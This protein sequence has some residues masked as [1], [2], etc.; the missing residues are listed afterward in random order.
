MTSVFNR[1]VIEKDEMGR[2]I[3][4]EKYT[5]ALCESHGEYETP[6]LNTKLH[7][8]CSGFHDIRNLENYTLL[9]ALWL[10]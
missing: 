2:N 1:L 9:A 5:R 4:T 8:N 6:S 10:Q 3:I 7:L